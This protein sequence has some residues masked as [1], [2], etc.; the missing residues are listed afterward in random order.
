LVLPAQGSES[1]QPKHRSTPILIAAGG[2]KFS[3]AK[4]VKFTIRL[5]ATG[6][7]MLNNAKSLRL[8][9]MGIYTPAG[10]LAVTTTTTF[11]LKR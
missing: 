5:T 6:K 1:D 2:A 3:Q 4:Q 9:G 7:R 10:N 8:T 11:R